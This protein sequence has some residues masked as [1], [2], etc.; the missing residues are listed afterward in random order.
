MMLAEIVIPDV[1]DVAGGIQAVIVAVG[2]V[3]LIAVGGALAFMVVRKG[4]KWASV[5]DGCQWDGV[6][7]AYEQQRIRQGMEAAAR[8]HDYERL[9]EW[10]D[11]YESFWGE[12]ARAEVEEELNKEHKLWL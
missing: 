1:V 12:E 10:G 6:S 5:S 2:G 11:R 4:L 9:R 7:L 8:D 3:A